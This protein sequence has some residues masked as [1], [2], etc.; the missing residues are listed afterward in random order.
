MGSQREG[1]LDFRAKLPLD[2]EVGTCG[3]LFKPIEIK[4]LPNYLDHLRKPFIPNKTMTIAHTPTQRSSKRTA[5]AKPNAQ[6]ALAAKATARFHAL[7]ARKQY[8]L[9]IADCEDLEQDMVVL[10]LVQEPKFDC[11]RASARTFAEIICRQSIGELLK[12]IRR[13]EMQFL[14]FD[15]RVA[16]NNDGAMLGGTHCPYQEDDEALTALGLD[17]ERASQSLPEELFELA[18]LL[19]RYQ[20]KSAA[21]HALGLHRVSFTRRFDALKMHMRMFGIRVS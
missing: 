4:H 5:T 3:C 17:W 7:M 13:H 19:L 6:Y 8:A 21:K 18:A 10:V 20:S 9:S 14:P 16:A 1:G 11:S 2:S 12:G 15:H